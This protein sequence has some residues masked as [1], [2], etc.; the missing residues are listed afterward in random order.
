MAN[1]VIFGARRGVGL[2]FSIGLPDLGD[3]VFLVS[4]TRPPSLERTPE[5]MEQIIQVNLLAAILC[6]HQLIPKDLVLL[7]RCLRQ[8]TRAFCVK[9]INIPAMPDHYKH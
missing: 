1:I 9:E 7:L 6:T 3:P 5:E 8:L 4:R 2:G